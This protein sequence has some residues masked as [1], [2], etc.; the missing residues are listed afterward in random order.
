MK[1]AED[2]GEL[3]GSCRRHV[4]GLLY[5]CRGSRPDVSFAVGTLSRRLHKWRK[6]DDRRRCRRRGPCRRHLL[7]VLPPPL[8][9]AHRATLR[10]EHKQRAQ[11]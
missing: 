3:A 2:P 4:C 1:D 9:S 7:C 8:R 11:L 5:V 6:I 10:G